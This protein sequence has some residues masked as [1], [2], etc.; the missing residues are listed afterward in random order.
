MRP[1]HFN[2]VFMFNFEKNLKIVKGRIRFIFHFND[3]FM[4]NFGKDFNTKTLIK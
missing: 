2:D 1:D 3:V 4:F